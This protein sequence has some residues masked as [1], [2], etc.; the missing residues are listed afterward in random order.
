MPGGHGNLATQHCQ[1][2]VGV[3]RIAKHSTVRKAS[4]HFSH[5]N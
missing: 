1:T 3:S 4:F 5:S 2:A